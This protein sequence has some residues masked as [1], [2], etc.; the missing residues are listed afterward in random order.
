[1]N[2]GVKVGE[3]GAKRSVELSCACLV[4]STARLR[5]VV[6]EVVGEELVEDFEIAAALHFFGVAANDGLGGLA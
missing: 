4:G 3:C 2:D 6:E 5:C 1:M